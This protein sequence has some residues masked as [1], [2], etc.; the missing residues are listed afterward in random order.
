MKLQERL[1]KREQ[2][3]RAASLLASDSVTFHD[4][5]NVLRVFRS[6]EKSLH[7]LAEMECNG[8]PKEQTEMRDGK[9][10][11]YSVEDESLKV[12]CQRGEQRHITAVI[13][14]AD[15]FGL[16]VEFQGDP[17]GLMF[18]ITKDGKEINYHD[19]F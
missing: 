12:R 7:R 6:H 4:A 14:L 9:V 1:W 10:Y 17:R 18:R 8:Y 11:S 13:D 3:F 16:V 2:E 5:L 15:K 19:T